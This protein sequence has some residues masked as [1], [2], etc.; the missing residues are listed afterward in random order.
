MAVGTAALEHVELRTPKSLLDEQ[1]PPRIRAEAVPEI[2][3]YMKGNPHFIVNGERM[4][5]EPV[6]CLSKQLPRRLGAEDQQE[7]TTSNHT[8]DT[9]KAEAP[10][11]FDGDEECV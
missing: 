3:N 9:L 6:T 1:L 4:G 8:K 11:V 5:M 10:F 2:I 7:L